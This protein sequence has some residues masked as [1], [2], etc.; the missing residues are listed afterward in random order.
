[1]QRNKK[2]NH[3]IRQDCTGKNILQ[4]MIGSKINIKSSRIM[5][6]VSMAT[7]A[8]TKKRKTKVLFIEIHQHP[9]LIKRSVANV[10]TFPAQ[11]TV[12][13]NVSKIQNLSVILMK[14]SFAR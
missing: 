10:I 4:P 14:I 1:M 13:V 8:R 3:E 11:R 7:V 12:N 5:V 6:T 9:P 2:K